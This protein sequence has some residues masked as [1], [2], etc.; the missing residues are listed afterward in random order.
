MSPSLNQ[1]Q[2]QQFK[3][4]ARRA[5][6]ANLTTLAEELDVIAQKLGFP[7]WS[8]LQRCQDAAAPQIILSRAIFSR[9]PEQMRG[10]VRKPKNRVH[11][12]DRIAESVRASLKDLSAEFHS[13]HEALEFAIAYMQCL[14]QLPRFHLHMASIAYF[15]MRAW[16]PYCVQE[17]DKDPSYRLLVG[18][19]YKPVGM[20][21]RERHVNY[22]DFP[23]LQVRISDDDL[24]ALFP[25]TDT[26]SS[27]Y[28][29]GG[30]PWHSRAN[31][32]KYLDKL[33]RL[34]DRLVLNRR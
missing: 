33:E 2:I 10:A 16:L 17:D 3:R 8:V 6:R 32:K 4:D 22:K 18:R 15:E 27:S 23:Q 25:A 11:S 34:R 29:Y 13:A 7:N 21:Q 24:S 12:S 1:S 5:K 30:S 20:V 26:H 31:A 28:L 19:D 9:T 14:L